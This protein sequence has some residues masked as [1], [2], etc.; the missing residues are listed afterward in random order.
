MYAELIAHGTGAHILHPE[1]CYHGALPKRGLC[2]AG[3][4]PSG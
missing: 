1:G 4:E 2:C 3:L